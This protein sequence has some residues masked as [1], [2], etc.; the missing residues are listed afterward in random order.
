MSAGLLI[1]ADELM[2]RAGDPNLAI[3]DCRARLEAPE[4]GERE[5][6]VAHIPGA[7]FAHLERDLSGEKT[8]RNGRHPLPTPEAIMARFSGWGIAPQTTVV[9]YDDVGGGLAAARLWWLL[10]Y[11][12]HERAL[13]LDGGWQAWMY[14]GGLIQ[15]GSQ[16]RAAGTF[17]GQPR[18]DMARD[19]DFVANVAAS[20]EGLVVDSRMGSRYRGEEEPFD[21]VAGHVPGARNHYWLENLAA[22]GRLLPPRQLRTAFERLL[23][24]VAPE[25]TIFYCG[26]GVTSAFQVFAMEVAGLPGAKIYPG[27]WSEWSTDP[28]RPVATG[29]R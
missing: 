3:F 22:D 20:G 7:V 6:L 25:R 9:A 26:S 29:D 27:S 24:G 8:G 5:Y 19:G 12:G 28:A 21:P 17:V 15:G 4:A 11:M 13:I 1:T 2:S 23:G 10:R 16:R 18:F 14:A